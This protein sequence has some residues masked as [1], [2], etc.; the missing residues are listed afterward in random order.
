MI[1]PESHSC[2][3]VPA[4]PF[5][6]KRPPPAGFRKRRADI[7]T[8]WTPQP[9]GGANRLAPIT[10][11]FQF[12]G[13]VGVSQVGN[14]APSD[15]PRSKASKDVVAVGGVWLAMVLSLAYAID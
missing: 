15:P 7:T 12:G 14:E 2:K 6:R 3:I 1:A 9:A 11:S 5:G 13:A 4:R 10:E 8:G